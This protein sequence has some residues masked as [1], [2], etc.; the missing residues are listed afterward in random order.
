MLKSIGVISVNV[1]I[2]LALASIALAASQEVKEAPPHLRGIW[3]A[4]TQS[5]DMG[6]TVERIVPTRIATVYA[7]EIDGLNGFSSDIEKLVEVRNPGEDPV[8]LFRLSR[9]IVWTVT[10]K[11]EPGFFMLQIMSGNPLKEVNRARTVPR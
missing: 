11:K 3:T 1:F 5:R 10:Q 8:Y 9:G 4:Y 7:S 6:M 2:S